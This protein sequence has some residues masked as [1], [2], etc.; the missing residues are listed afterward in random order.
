[1]LP[2]AYCNT[3]TISDNTV[4]HNCIEAAIDGSLEATG[5]IRISP[6]GNTAH[7]IIVENNTV[8][9][10]GYTLGGT[11]YRGKGIWVDTAG[12]NIIV[13]YNES[14]DNHNMGIILEDQ[15]NTEVYYNLCYGNGGHGIAARKGSD[16]NEIY[17]NVCYDNI[18]GLEVNGLGGTAA[19]NLIKNNIS[20]NNSSCELSAVD[21]GENPA[22]NGNVYEYNCFGAEA[23]NFIEW[24]ATNYDSTYD[25]WETSYG[26]GTNSV[27]ADP[28]MTDPAN[29]DFTLQKTSPCR[30]AGTDVGLTQDYRGSRVPKGSAPDIGAYEYFKAII[31]QPIASVLNFF[32]AMR[33]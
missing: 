17:N 28:L 3:W 6:D 31:W 13:R 30:D 24:G 33:N 10:N 23:A 8:Y 19:S 7:T 32:T 25:D 18:H 29:N 21:G 16:S 20:I 4:H 22:G 2:G 26:S 15:D 9:S 11:D 14:Y 12:A 5:G 27:E 1:M